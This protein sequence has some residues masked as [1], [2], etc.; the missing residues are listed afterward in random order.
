MTN[1][2]ALQ[3]FNKKKT[4]HLIISII[5]DV[6]GMTTYLI[7]LLGEAGDIIFA[8][9]YGL[10]IFIMYRRK[11]FPAVAGGFAGTVEELLPGTDIIPTATIMW[12]FTYIMRKESTLKSFV[13]TKN[14]EIAAMNNLKG[15]R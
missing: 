6:L 9:F 12:I 11:I 15:L 7:P 2:Q 4:Q 1:E 10:A 5:L 14:K 3:E 13:K 8:P